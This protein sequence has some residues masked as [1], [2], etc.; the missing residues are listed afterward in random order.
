M[1]LSAV[2]DCGIFLIIL[3]YYYCCE[4]LPGGATFCLHFKIVVFPD[5]THLLFLCFYNSRNSVSRRNLEKVGGY[6]HSE[7][8]TQY[9]Q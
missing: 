9:A 6:G 5:H 4:A 8:H 7:L 1:G 3:S 2:G